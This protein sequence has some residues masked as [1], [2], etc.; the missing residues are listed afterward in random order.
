MIRTMMAGIALAGTVAAAPSAIAQ[1][2]DETSYVGTI[3]LTGTDFCPWGT[4]PAVGQQLEA[5]QFPALFSLLTNTFG[6]NGQTTFNLPDL[7]NKAPVDGMQYCI[8][9]DGIYPPRP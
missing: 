8:V 3:F 1:P 4:A 6:G 7:R 2:M 5:A 9:I